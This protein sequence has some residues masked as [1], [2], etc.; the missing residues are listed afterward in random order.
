MLGLLAGYDFNLSGNRVVGLEVDGVYDVEDEAGGLV[1]LRTYYA[2]PFGGGAWR[3][4][5]GIETTYA[6]EDYMS[7]YFGI[8]ASDSARSG[9]SKFSADAGFLDVGINASLTYKFTD[10]WSTTGL[11][12]YARLLGDAEDSPVT[13][14]AGSANQLFA[15]MLVNYSF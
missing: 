5:G 10:H 13:D 11:A 12:R 14:D 7:E 1:T 3:F 8:N 4:R 9:L 6:S 15:G 2:A